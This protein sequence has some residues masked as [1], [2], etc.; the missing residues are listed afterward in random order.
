MA[1]QLVVSLEV[2]RVLEIEL[3]CMPLH[4]NFLKR[5]ELHLLTVLPVKHERRSEVDHAHQVSNRFHDVPREHNIRACHYESKLSDHDACTE[6][7]N[8]ICPF[9]CTLVEF[10]LDLL[11]FKNALLFGE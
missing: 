1:R 8:T 6:S 5:D 11:K 2:E 3:L 7:E 4:E 10:A 9:K